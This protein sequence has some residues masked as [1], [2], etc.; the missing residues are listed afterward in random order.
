MIVS[1]KD[2]YIDNLTRKG[3]TLTNESRLALTFHKPAPGDRLEE[4]LVYY[5]WTPRSRA[6]VIVP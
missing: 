3:W 1:M 4:R 6:I 5:L 2:W